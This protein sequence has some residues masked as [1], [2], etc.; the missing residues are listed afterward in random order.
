MA[1]THRQFFIR[2]AILGLVVA[3]LLSTATRP[4]SAS[5][6][7]V[8]VNGANSLANMCGWMGG[9]SQMDVG[10]TNA[11]GIYGIK[12][13]CI[14]GGLDGL[15][16]LFG[17]GGTMHCYFKWLRPDL[18]DIFGRPAENQIRPADTAEDATPPPDGASEGMPIIETASGAEG[19]PLEPSAEETVDTGGASEEPVLD[20]APADGESVEPGVAEPMADD[21]HVVTAEAATDPVTDTGMVDE[22]FEPVVAEE[23]GGPVLDETAVYDDVPRLEAAE[24]VDASEGQFYDESEEDEAEG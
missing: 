12:V 19:E 16:C 15:V 17:T 3:A 21:G 13:T 23:S 9:T 1:T 24:V 6:S 10:R 5:Q 4:A 14:G 11:S 8:D 7:G 22:V 2:M 20:P 18:V